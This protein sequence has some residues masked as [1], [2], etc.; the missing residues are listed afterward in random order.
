MGL[1]LIAYTLH[2]VRHGF[3]FP[4][5][6]L[7]GGDMGAGPSAIGFLV[8][9]FSL[10][11]VF[12]SVPLGGLADRF[13]VKRLLVFGV[14]CNIGNAVVLL[15]A[16]D[17]AA[18]IIAQLLG[19]LAFQLHVIASQAYISRLREPS[20]RARLFGYIS[21]FAGVGQTA[22]P[23]LGG[24]LA[25]RFGYHTAFLVVLALSIGGL[26]I[27]GLRE[28]RSTGP[29]EPSYSLLG[30]LR[31]AATLTS[32]ARLLMM[33][34]FT[35]SII[36]AASLRSSFL[37]V[38]LRD[39]G[40]SEAYVGLLL[41]LFA[42]TATIV[43]IFFGRIIDALGKRTNILV[44]VIAVA[45]GVGLIPAMPSIAGLGL[46]LI[47]FG[48][49]F[50]ISQPLSMVL[51]ADLT[52]PKRSGLAM[53]LRFTSIMLA[54]LLGPIVLGFVVAGFGMGAAF[55]VAA[56]AVIAAGIHILVKK[57]GKPALDAWY[58]G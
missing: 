10:M 41:S 8:G 18:L 47:I 25:A 38:H 23:A 33:L 9:S 7:L 29:M 50:G 46:V 4:L 20:K 31:Q 54:E 40:F 51:I 12:L 30:D 11:A 55:F 26:A 42:G 56:A 32:D 49:G 6:P 14:I 34:S 27:L 19:G 57:G 15:S 5:I 37:P 44:S 17:L 48:L 28:I 45:I 21:F 39:R 35:F 52:D 58:R 53:G 13:G 2:F 36:F 43:R 16:G 1:I 22:G 24:F 3:V